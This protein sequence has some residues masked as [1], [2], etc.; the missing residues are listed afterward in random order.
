MIGIPYIEDV[1][2]KALLALA[3]QTKQTLQDKV[4]CATFLAQEWVYADC[5]LDRKYHN[6]DNEQYC[7]KNLKICYSSRIASPDKTTITKGELAVNPMYPQKEEAYII[8]NDSFY[9]DG[10]FF[11]NFIIDDIVFLNRHGW[12]KYPSGIF[13]PFGGEFLIKKNAQQRYSS[14]MDIAQA[15]FSKANQA[16]LYEGWELDALSSGYKRFP[17]IAG[18]TFCNKIDT[19]KESWEHSVQDAC[20]KEILLE[21]TWINVFN[22]IAKQNRFLLLGLGFEL[23]I[24]KEL[25]IVIFKRKIKKALLQYPYDSMLRELHDTLIT[26]TDVSNVIYQTLDYDR[27]AG[28]TS[29][30]SHVKKRHKYNWVGCLLIIGII[31][32]LLFLYFFCIRDYNYYSDL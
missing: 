4:M 12:K 3:S 30:G 9:G 32:I 15:F 22:N 26:T 14:M 5:D 18:F 20:E 13:L 7:L 11:I 29:W 8:H 31:I 25:S 10:S 28:A 21:E 17:I 6:G 16:L 27:I 19:K 23:P 2:P 24:L 1:I